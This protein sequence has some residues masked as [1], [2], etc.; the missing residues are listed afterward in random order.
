MAKVTSKLQVTIPKRIADRYGIRPGNEID[1]LEAGDAIRVL[2]GGDRPEDAGLAGRRV[3]LFDAATAR[4][5][6]RQAA[7]ARAPG[8]GGRAWSR[9]DLY[10]R[11]RA[12]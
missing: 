4:Q 12:D 5:H 1:W 6:E 7:D 9:E 10:V 2:P 8:P 3:E 11:G